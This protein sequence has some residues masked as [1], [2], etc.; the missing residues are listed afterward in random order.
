MKYATITILRAQY[1]LAVLCRVLGVSRCGYL[2]HT[3][4]QRRRQEYPAEGQR[5]SDESLLVHICSI[6]AAS[7]QCYDWP[8]SCAHRACV[9]AKVCAASCSAMACP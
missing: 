6:H 2:Q 5:I 4:R 7:H 9:W 1:P 3:E 8:R